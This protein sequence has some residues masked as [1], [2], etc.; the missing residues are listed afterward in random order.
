MLN[1]NYELVQSNILGY[2]VTPTEIWET[3][4]QSFFVMANYKETSLINENI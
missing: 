1:C 3:L 4:I 2:I